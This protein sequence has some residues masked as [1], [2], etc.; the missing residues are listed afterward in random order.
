[1]ITA[2]RWSIWSI[3]AI[4][5]SQSLVFPKFPC[6]TISFRLT[7][8]N[9]H[10]F[11]FHC[12]DK[13]Q[14]IRWVSLQ[15]FLHEMSNISNRDLSIWNSLYTERMFVQL[16]IGIF[17]KAALWLCSECFTRWEVQRH[18]HD[19]PSIV[20]RLIL[21]ST[22]HNPRF[23]PLITSSLCWTCGFSS[24]SLLRHTHYFVLCSVLRSRSL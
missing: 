8:H 3:H 4:N 22:D 1:M 13:A 10:S 12:Y 18:L 14:C 24:H 7:M 2:R 20:S 17:E 21:F 11:S 15:R 16:C 23:S 19:W 6:I 9:F 5:S